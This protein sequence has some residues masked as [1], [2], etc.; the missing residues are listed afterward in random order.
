MGVC[1]IEQCRPV[2]L[3]ENFVRIEMLYGNLFIIFV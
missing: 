1:L 2:S 3:R